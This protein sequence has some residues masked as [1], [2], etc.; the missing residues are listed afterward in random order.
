MLFCKLQVLWGLLIDFLLAQA[1]S[2]VIAR[3]IVH[4]TFIRKFMEI[5]IARLRELH[6]E[7]RYF[8]HFKVPALLAEITI[9]IKT[10]HNACK[11]H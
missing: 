5:P 2:R 6:I 9:T 3:K 4:F 11:H 8:C 7:S 10:P 1:L